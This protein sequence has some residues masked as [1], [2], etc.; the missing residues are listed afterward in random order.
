MSDCH[1]LGDFT[2][3]LSS[4]SPVASLS[5]LRQRKGKEF[6]NVNELAMR[7]CCFMASTQVGN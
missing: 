4:A 5:Y 6:S 1:Y 7:R 3:M 2:L